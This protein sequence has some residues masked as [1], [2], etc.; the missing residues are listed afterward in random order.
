[1]IPV[2][3][4]PLVLTLF[5][6]TTLFRS[7]GREFHRRARQR[8]EEGP[9]R[10]P[11]GPAGKGAAAPPCLEPGREQ[12]RLGHAAPDGPVPRNRGVQVVRLLRRRS[13]RGL[14]GVRRDRK[15]VV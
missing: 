4:P 7:C 1:F 9:V 10:V 15:S 14:R 2:D 5:P 11:P 13:G 3:S 8:R 6:Y 12:G